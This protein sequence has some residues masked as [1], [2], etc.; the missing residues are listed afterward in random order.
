MFSAYAGLFCTTAAACLCTSHAAAPARPRQ[1]GS[2]IAFADCEGGRRGSQE[3]RSLLLIIDAPLFIVVA[4]GYIFAMASLV[5]LRSC[6]YSRVL[7][8]VGTVLTIAGCIVVGIRDPA[9]VCGTK[10][11][12]G[13]AS[14]PPCSK[15]WPRVQPF[16]CTVLFF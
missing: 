10:G 11:A 13:L 16:V 6:P 7:G 12:V 4:G 5:I 1:E 3:L 9:E 15:T 2:D 8:I 14:R